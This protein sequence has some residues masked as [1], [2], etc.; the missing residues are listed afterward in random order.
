[1]EI[2][3]ICEIGKNLQKE[4]FTQK[5]VI[6]VELITHCHAAS[7]YVAAYFDK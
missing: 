4:K 6:Y 3:I 2:N 5:L 7:V 1:M